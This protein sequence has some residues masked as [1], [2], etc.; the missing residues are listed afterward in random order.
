MQINA[1]AFCFNLLGK[2]KYDKTTKYIYARGLKWEKQERER[3]RERRS[4][5]TTQKKKN[6][7]KKK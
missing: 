6:W 1:E 2:R 5:R 7:I 4:R 3:E